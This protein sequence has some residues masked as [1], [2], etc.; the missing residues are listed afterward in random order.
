M[1]RYGQ[2][3]ETPLGVAAGPHT[4]LSQNLIS[5]WLTGARYLELKTVQVLDEIEVTKPCIDMT[6]EGYNCEWSQEL[7]LDQSFRRIPER[8]DRAAHPEGQVRLGIT[9]GA[10]FHL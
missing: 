1:R 4:Q 9:G 8:M 3:L 10:G 6:D 2:L 5:A 7:K